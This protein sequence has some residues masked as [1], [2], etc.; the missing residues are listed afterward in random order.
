MA[1]LLLAQVIWTGVFQYCF[2]RVFMTIVAVVTQVLKRYCLE[3]LSPAFAHIWVMG[4]EAVAVTI[5]MYCII[6]FYLQV[7]KDIPQHKPLLKV[8][9]I[10]L[11]IF[12]SFWQTIIISFLT[13]SGLI[14]PSKKFQTPDI[15]V[16]IPS[17]L[18]CVEMAF[19]A[20]FHFFAFGWK[21]YTVSSKAYQQEMAGTPL[22]YK[23]GFLGIKAL[24]EAANPWDMIKAVARAGKWL[25]VGRRKRML[26]SSYA[27]S[28][29]DTGESMDHDPTA[30]SN[31]KLNPL[32]GSTAYTGSR[33]AKAAGYDLDEDQQP[34]VH[35]QPI[36]FFDASSSGGDHSLYSL[37]NTESRDAGDIGVSNSQFDED[38]D[39]SRGRPG[40]GPPTIHIRAPSGQETGVVPYPDERS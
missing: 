37:A 27:V 3:S 16:G 19:F 15:K 28:R 30:Y 39:W 32:N 7:R 26:D 4:I 2:I 33:S 38:D 18:L 23:G 12:L 31:T 17:L 40:P 25:F 34:L 35:D 11:V 21:D 24:A 22:D 9:A 13:S 36:P 8:L 6:Q 5:A 20:F 10:K 1:N 29:T 14:K